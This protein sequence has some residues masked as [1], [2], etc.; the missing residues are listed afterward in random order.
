MGKIMEE[1]DL[2]GQGSRIEEGACLKGKDKP[3]GK[4]ASL[5]S[6]TTLQR[7]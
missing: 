7:S 4:I 6:G 2:T 1:N 5:A 3:L